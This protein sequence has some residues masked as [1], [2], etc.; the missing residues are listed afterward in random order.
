[1]K[2]EMRLGISAELHSYQDVHLYSYRWALSGG[3]L[4]PNPPYPR[5]NMG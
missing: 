3:R 1:V 5:L 4:K 2:L